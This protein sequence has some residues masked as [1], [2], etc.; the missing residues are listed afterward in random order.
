M[1]RVDA[2]QHFWD[3]ATAH[4]PWMSDAV[5]PLCRRFGP[6]DLAPLLRENG[7]DCSIVVQARSDL[8]ETREFMAFAADNEFV[9]GAVGWVDLTDPGVGDVLDELLGGPNGSKLVGV[10]HQAE[11]EPDPDWLVRDDVQRGLKAVAE[12]G[13][14]YD[15]LVRPPNLPA[16]VKAVRALPDARFVVDHIAK[17]LI[18]AGELEP[19]ESRLREVAAA[20]NA[21]CKLSGLITE[22][23]R[24]NWKTADLVPYVERVVDMF[25]TERLLFGSDWPVVLLAGSYQD[26]VD[27]TL[28]ALPALSPSELDAVMGGNAVALYRPEGVA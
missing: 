24:E 7:I 5:A 4:Y 26:A 23:D 6:D 10:R 18:K 12:R 22:A 25:G 1:A 2:H 17:P 20:P 13:L 8:V 21:W 14:V 11:D 19:W 28:E 16:A 27:S 9:A 3:P 15:L